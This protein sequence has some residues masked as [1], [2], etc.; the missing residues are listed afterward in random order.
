MDDLSMLPCH[1]T[2]PVVEVMVAVVDAVLA[3]ATTEAF[4]TVEINQDTKIDVAA[5]VDAVNMVDGAETDM[6]SVS[7]DPTPGTIL[8]SPKTQ[9]TIRIPTPIIKITVSFNHFFHSRLSYP[10][11][12]TF[13]RL[14]LVSSP[15]TST[16]LD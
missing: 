8:I 15:R 5:D 14:R 9:T 2:T 7:I 11:I 4:T 3:V 12:N 10:K 1:K 6:I 16:F 13:H